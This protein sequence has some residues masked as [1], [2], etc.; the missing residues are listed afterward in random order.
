MLM[1]R[2]PTCW[3]HVPF[4]LLEIRQLERKGAR[5][6]VLLVI[7]SRNEW[8][9]QWFV[10][11][12]GF[13][14]ALF[15]LFSSFFQC[16][17][18]AKVD[19]TGRSQVFWPRGLPSWRHNLVILHRV[20]VERGK[21]HLLD[22]LIRWIRKCICHQLCILSLNWNSSHSSHCWSKCLG[23]SNS[24]SPALAC[25][26]SCALNSMLIIDNV[27]HRFFNHYIII[28]DNYYILLWSIMMI[29]QYQ[30]SNMFISINQHTIILTININQCNWWLSIS[31]S[32][33]SHNYH[34]VWSLL[35]LIIVC[36][37]I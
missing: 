37:Y 29:S 19:Q 16:L 27:H 15:T 5:F 20:H 31:V 23:E 11:V 36:I 1:W 12:A 14:C 17:A 8:K 35:M 28:V 4:K 10:A 24:V 13:P 34:P 18:S 2:V 25:L 21:K 26:K 32:V 30:W 22:R 7:V 33:I 3:S 6:L 9:P